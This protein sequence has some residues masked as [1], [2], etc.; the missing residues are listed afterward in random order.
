MSPLSY[1]EQTTHFQCRHS[2]QIHV[3]TGSSHPSHPSRS[4]LVLLKVEFEGHSLEASAPVCKRRLQMSVAACSGCRCSCHFP[5]RTA[6]HHRWASLVEH[7]KELPSCVQ[8]TRWWCPAPAGRVESCF[9]RF[10]PLPRRKKALSASQGKLLLN[11]GYGLSTSIY[12]SFP[13][14]L[15]CVGVKRPIYTGRFFFFGFV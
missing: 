6:W 10:E 14:T 2:P 12:N 7:L 4:D 9:E 3:A 1:D 11:K 5:R 13:K 15:P 8:V